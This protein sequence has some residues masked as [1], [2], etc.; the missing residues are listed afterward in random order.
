MEKIKKNNVSILL[1]ISI[2]SV[3][4]ISTIIQ[5][6]TSAEEF[7]A[8]KLGLKFKYDESWKLQSG[9]DPSKCNRT[10]C[11]FTLKNLNDNN[12]S[13]AVWIQK[14]HH[15]KNNICKCDSLVEFVQYDYTKNYEPIKTFSLINDNQ[16]TLNGNITVMQMEYASGGKGNTQFHY[17]ISW[18]KNNDIFYKIAYQSDNNNNFNRFLPN[19][20]NILNSI[21]LFDP[22][23]KL[24]SS[25]TSNELQSIS[26]KKK[27]SF[28]IPNNKDNS[29]ESLNQQETINQQQQQ[30]LSKL[31]LYQDPKGKFTLEYDPSLWIAIPDKNRFDQIELH[32]VGKEIGG[33]DVGLSIGVVKDPTPN[34]SIKEATELV[35]PNYI[36][37]NKYEDKQLEEGVECK[38]MTI[39]GYDTCSFIY[40]EPKSYFDTYPRIYFMTVNAKLGDELWIATFTAP[41][42]KFEGFEESVIQMLN[43][44][45]ITNIAA[46]QTT[47]TTTNNL[48]SSSSSITNNCDPINEST[49]TLQNTLNPK[50]VLL[51]GNF[52]PCKLVNGELTLNIPENPNL[53]LTAMYVD[54]IGNDHS[55]ALINPTKI[56]NI[57]KN[58][59]LFTI[60]LDKNMKGIDPITGKNTTLTKINGLALYNNGDKPIVFKPGNLVTLTAATFTK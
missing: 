2:F 38:K 37:N 34:I 21:Q 32:F 49:I 14:G 23:K 11:I 26:E 47:T 13:L 31:T 24:Q 41:G 19:A 53:K 33:N 3:I 58:Q 15:F 46:G 7:N 42:D 16:T 30:Q 55:G 6:N 12:T 50:E 10:L 44:M 1:L 51:L 8:E 35:L 40:S 29:I 20:K 36:G 4:S 56:Q 17:L 22:L 18:I 52:Y 57:D 60:K 27:P 45:K 28:M 43:S 5:N 9:T 25:M 54:H 59:G 48:F 39:Q